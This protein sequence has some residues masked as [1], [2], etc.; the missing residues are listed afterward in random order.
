MLHCWTGGPKWTRRF[1]DLGVTFSFAGPV[2]FDTGDTVRRGAAVAPPERTMVETDTPYLTPPPDRAPPTSRPTWCGSA[3][4]SPR[5]G[6]STS[7]GW[8]SSP[9]PPP[10]GSSGRAQTTAH[11]LVSGAQGRGEIVEL[12]ARHGHH[13]N[14]RLGQHFLADPNL[15]ARIVAAAGVGPGDLVVEVGSGTGTLTRAL[16]ASGAEVIG[17]RDRPP[18]RAG[19]G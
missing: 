5:C 3:R 10:P 9:P 16:A 15:V 8:P 17:L 2:T 7:T 6:G 12:L 13:P 18:S 1:A 11:G 14:K 19:P 4:R